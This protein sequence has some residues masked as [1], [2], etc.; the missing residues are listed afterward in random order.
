[1]KSSHRKSLE[2]KY[3]LSRIKECINVLLNRGQC[4]AEPVFSNSNVSK[5]NL[6]GHAR[7]FFSIDMFLKVC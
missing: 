2:C 3:C 4:Q 7:K 1:M 5:S 6:E